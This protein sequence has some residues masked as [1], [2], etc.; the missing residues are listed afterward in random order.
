MKG[1]Q[2]HSMCR[3]FWIEQN[4]QCCKVALASFRSRSCLWA[5][6][7]LDCLDMSA[8]G[9]CTWGTPILTGT[10]F[11]RL[12]NTTT[13]P[14]CTS[15]Q[16]VMRS[17]RSCWSQIGRSRGGN[18]VQYFVVEIIFARRRISWN[19]MRS[20]RRSCWAGHG[21]TLTRIASSFSTGRR[22]EE[23]T[24]N[25]VKKPTLSAQVREMQQSQDTVRR[26]N[27]FNCVHNVIRCRNHFSNK[28]VWSIVLKSCR[29][30]EVPEKYAMDLKD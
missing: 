6:S 18:N 20:H 13:L 2:I 1:S 3:V 30:K 8:S 16:N 14:L 21:S 11:T 19:N 9:F 17:A 24:R 28:V 29:P 5:S 27:I 22:R 10:N 7:K 15:T 25:L 26:E 4:R 12:P 23:V